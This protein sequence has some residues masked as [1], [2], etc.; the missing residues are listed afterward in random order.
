MN[1][2]AIN[3]TTV[4]AKG[5]EIIVNLIR[6]GEEDGLTVQQTA[7]L[8]EVTQSAVLKHLKRH[9]LT[10]GQIVP[11]SLQELK[12][13][14]VIP[15]RTK[16]ALWLPRETVRQLSTL[17]GTDVAKEITKQLFEALDKPV[18][19]VKV[20]AEAK[21]LDPMEV[22]DLMYA[23]LKRQVARADK[24]E[25]TIKL[26]P[27]QIVRDNA[28]AAHEIYRSYPVI[29]RHT[30]SFIGENSALR[31]YGP[32]GGLTIFLREKGVERLRVDGK[33]N[34]YSVFSRAD[35]DALENTLGGVG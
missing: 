29:T 28:I 11:Q 32:N 21:N 18:E 12:K 3:K 5:K 30:K 26:S 31:K 19:A 8:F 14:K 7:D 24:A 34:S 17:I 9:S 35:L 2:I 4:Q 16:T 6:M 22:M 13:A 23:E 20:H 25:A 33:D 15:L 27:V 1:N 10:A